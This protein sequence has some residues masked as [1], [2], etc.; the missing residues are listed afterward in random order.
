MD[1]KIRDYL[2]EIGRKG[3]LQGKRALTSDAARAMVQLREA[4][5]AFREFRTR[6]FW[7]A[8]PSYRVAADDVPW[9][10]EQLRKNGGREAYA[11]A[12]RIAGY[13]ACR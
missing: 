8:D 2:A 4:R 9:V 11:A 6:C 5:R 3:G 1:P 12:A 7:S 13:R 10:L